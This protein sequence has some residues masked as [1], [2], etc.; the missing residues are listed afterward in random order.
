[1]NNKK[2][3][4]MAEILIAFTIVG[5]VAILTIPSVLEN[6]EKKEWKARKKAFYS[7]L[8]QA[9]DM[10]PKIAGYGTYTVSEDENS[11]QIITDTAA[12]AFVTDGLSKVMDIRRVCDNDE[13][14]KCGISSKIWRMPPTKP[15]Y[16]DPSTQVNFPKT[17]GELNPSFI[18]PHQHLLSWGIP[19]SPINTKTVA[20]ETVN[21][22]S[23]SVFY[24]PFC[25]MD[26]KE[27]GSYSVMNKM[28]VNFIYDVNGLD[29]PNTL[30]DDIGI[31]TVLY[32]VMPKL[33]Q[34]PN[35]ASLYGS[36]NPAV[37]TYFGKDFHA[38]N[39]DE[40]ILI[41]VN[42]KLFPLLVWTSGT[43]RARS[44]SWLNFGDSIP[45]SGQ[46]AA[47]YCIKTK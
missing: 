30:G 33:V 17:I 3:F 42:K 46:D 7:R 25:Q 41:F 10:M 36:G 37:C 9:I 5:I 1:M 39:L 23:V 8:S 28:C 4:T 16:S 38:P 12:M 29:Q 31:I 18:S 11:S 24:N 44:G 32:S 26:L 22:E 34:S 6:F 2:S 20:F 47:I 40:L 19:Y 27:K 15:K 45:L 35:A 14:Q 43:Y 13:L 21:G